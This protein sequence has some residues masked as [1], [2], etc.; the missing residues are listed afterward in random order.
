MALVERKATEGK[1]ESVRAAEEPDERR[2]ADVIDL[3]ELLKRSLGGGGKAGDKA[4]SPSRA[5]TAT[6][7]ESK[8]K[9]AAK[10]TRK[11]APA[12]GEKKKAG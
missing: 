1:I 2:S 3:T 10:R 4:S 12:K 6:K 9:P 7:E 5:K 8:S 11:A